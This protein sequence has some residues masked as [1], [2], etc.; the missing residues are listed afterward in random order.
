MISRWR[1][2]FHEDQF[3]S[4]YAMEM[5]CT[6][7]IT[8]ILTLTG[9]QGQDSIKSLSVTIVQNSVN[10]NETKTPQSVSGRTLILCLCNWSTCP[11][12]FFSFFYY[13]NEFIT[14]VVVEW[15]QQSGFTG[16]SSH[17][18]S[19]SCISH[20]FYTRN[21]MQIEQ[22]YSILCALSRVESNRA[23]GPPDSP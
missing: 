13:S 15:S 6:P 14:S 7:H 23:E 19:T 20:I 4:F 22:L 10:L 3:H 5:D 9:K 16:F 8:H 21:Y 17:S 12:F 11:H 1:T 2:Y 18:P